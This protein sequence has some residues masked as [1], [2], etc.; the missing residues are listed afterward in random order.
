MKQLA[1][2]G[3]ACY[4]VTMPGNLVIF[5]MRVIA[6]DKYPNLS[7]D[8]I[9]YKELEEVFRE[10]DLISLHCPLTIDNYHMINAK[11]ISLWKPSVTRP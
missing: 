2:N 11:T 10:S 3:L 5:G 8:F 7:L 1:A 4:R 6:Y 9:E